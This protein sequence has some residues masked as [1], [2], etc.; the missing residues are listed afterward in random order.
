MSGGGPKKPDGSRVG[1]LVTVAGGGV[2]DPPD[3]A[4]GKWEAG[5]FDVRYSE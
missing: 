1:R 5:T 3:L 4:N 2:T